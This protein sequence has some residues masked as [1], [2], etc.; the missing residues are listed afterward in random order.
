MGNATKIVGE[1]EEYLL[2]IKHTLKEADDDEICVF[3]DHIKR[4]LN[5]LDGMFSI[6]RKKHAKKEKARTTRSVMSSAG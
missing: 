5:M 1:I 4:V 6:L 3:C 2:E